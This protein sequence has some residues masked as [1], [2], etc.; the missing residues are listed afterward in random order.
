M[1]GAKTTTQVQA[2]VPD[3]KDCGVLSAYEIHMGVT[4]TQGAGQPAFEII[5]RN[6]QPVKVADGWVS[7]T[8]ASGHVS[9]RPV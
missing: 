7:R 1:A 6:G 9:P 8:A 5:S 4:E 2:R 3:A